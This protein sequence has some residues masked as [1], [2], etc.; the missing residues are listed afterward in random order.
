MNILDMLLGNQGQSTT[1][2]I[3]QQLGLSDVQVN[4]ALTALAPAVAAGFKNHM[5]TEQ[6][7]N[8]LVAALDSGQHQQYVDDPSTLLRPDAT[9]DGNG[10]LSH[11]F[12]SKD[13]S[14]E[15]ANR[16]SAQTG[17]DAGVLRGLLPVVAA[18]MMGRMATNNSG[19]SASAKGSSL[20]GMLT[21]MLGARHDGSILED[22]AGLVGRFARG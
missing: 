1:Q 7:L 3:G 16:A 12:R 5:S 20:L 17:L 19:G 10:I 2:Q 14:R 15:V 8:G 13:V 11:I 4:S 9:N 21:P 18:L 6:G 22:V